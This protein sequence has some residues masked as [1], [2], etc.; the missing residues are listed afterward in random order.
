MIEGSSVRQVDKAFTQ[1]A[2][3]LGYLTTDGLVSSPATA[4]TGAR[5]YLLDRALKNVG[6]DAVYFAADTPLIY[7][8]KRDA[9][10]PHDIATL[11]RRVWNDGR[12]PLLFVVSPTEVRLY[13]G[14]ALPTL[15]P[16]KVDDQCLVRRLELTAN[17]LEQLADFRRPQVETGETWRNNVG[18]F[19]VAARCDR[20][21]LENL[22]RARAHFIAERNLPEAIVD[23]LLT[24]SILLFYLEHRS[25][26]TSKYYERFKPGAD[27]L[28]E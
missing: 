10:D 5:R 15:D 12:V 26:L 27:K 19:N 18:H 8:A 4:T 11:H 28:T 7:F 23:Q 1:I 13:D 2:S 6:A 22:R 14:F 16:S 9:F 24:R 3:S 20:T 25:V 17:V 21:L